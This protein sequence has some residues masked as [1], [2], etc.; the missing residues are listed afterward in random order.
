MPP[1]RLGGVSYMKRRLP[2]SADDGDNERF[3]P[4]GCGRLLKQK[5]KILTLD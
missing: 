5:I 3:E 4:T 1:F 2:E